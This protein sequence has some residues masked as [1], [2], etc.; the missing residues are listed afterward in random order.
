MSR[1]ARPQDERGLDQSRLRFDSQWDTEDQKERELSGGRSSRRCHPQPGTNADDRPDRPT[2]TMPAPSK[3]SPVTG[4]SVPESYIHSSS[5]F[6]RGKPLPSLDDAQGR[7]RPTLFLAQT[8]RAGTS[9]CAASIS[10]ALLNPLSRSRRTCWTTSGSRPSAGASRSS[11]SRCGSMTARRTST[12]RGSGGG[13][14]TC[15]DTSSPGSRSSTRDRQSSLR[16]L[17]PSLARSDSFAP[18]SVSGAS[19]TRSLWSTRSR[20]F[21]SARSTAS[22]CVAL[23][24]HTVT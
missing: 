15:S 18:F 21:A 2:S 17:S 16:L 10:L 14:S 7:R 9:S 13:G 22:E 20:S 12:S 8:P 11:A 3:T 19:M 5:A 1:Q 6:F 24:L 23:V 4:E